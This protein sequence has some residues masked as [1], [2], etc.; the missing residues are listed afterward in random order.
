MRRNSK[1]DPE[2]ESQSSHFSVMN[3]PVVPSSALSILPT[4]MTAPDRSARPPEQLLFALT[5]SGTTPSADPANDR[6]TRDT[7]TLLPHSPVPSAFSFLLSSVRLEARRSC[8]HH[9]S[10]FSTADAVLLERVAIRLVP[11]SAWINGRAVFP[12]AGCFVLS[13]SMAS[14]A[15]SSRWPKTILRVVT[16]LAVLIGGVFG[17]RAIWRQVSPGLFGTKRQET[18]PTVKVRTAS[19]AEEI[20]AVGRLRAVFSTELRSEITGRIVKILCTDGQ[21]VERSQEILSGGRL[22]PSRALARSLVIGVAF[23]GIV[24][25]LA[26]LYPAIRAPRG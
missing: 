9:W 25:V 11:A 4:S 12:N 21:K 3:I 2:R 22:E 24:G 20:V 5:R 6:L 15:S 26:G 8:R 18:V 14:P 17:S 23:S 7:P 16:V 13:Y 10:C 1:V 19:I